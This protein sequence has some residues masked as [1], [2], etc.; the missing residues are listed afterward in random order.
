LYL[1]NKDLTLCIGTKENKFALIGI[2][3]SL[4]VDTGIWADNI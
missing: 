4:N 3:L 2:D 1:P